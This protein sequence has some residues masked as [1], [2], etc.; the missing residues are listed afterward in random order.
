M[1][2]AIRIHN[3]GGPEALQ[4]E[5]VPVADPGAGQVQIRVHATTLNPIDPLRASGVAR[6]EFALTFPWIPGSDISG[7]IEKV[8]EGVTGLSVGD[9]VYGDPPDSTYA[10]LA[11]VDAGAV[12]IKPASLS[13]AEAAAAG[14][15]TQTAWQALDAAGIVSGQR[16]LIHGAGGAV[17]SAAVQLAHRL[18]AYVIATASGPDT[19]YVRGLGADEVIDYKTTPFETV[20]KD[21]DA[22]LDT[23]G[24]N[25]QQR[26]F[27]VLK[28]GGVIVA[29][30]QF[31]SQEEAAKHNVNAVMIDTKPSQEILAKLAELLDSG[32][33]KVRV[34]KTY[35]LSQAADAWR[36]SKTQSI[37]G[38]IVLIA[39]E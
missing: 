5:D 1:S 11:N 32:K 17:G 3:Y 24:G 37:K 28:P 31:P 14:V 8:G 13:H 9:A 21:A 30:N 29:L 39:T 26:S 7:V 16:I 36:D 22:V 12:A 15:V 35:P 10:E 27:G 23:V 2:K 19:E 18:G 38:K 20:V 34:G 33:L 4:E 25:T 6:S